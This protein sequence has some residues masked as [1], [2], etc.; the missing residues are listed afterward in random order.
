MHGSRSLA[1]RTSRIAAAA[2]LLAAG[3][4]ANGCA[5]RC[6][7]TLQTNNGPSRCIVDSCPKNSSFNDAV[8]ACAC[9]AGFVPF[10]GACQDVAS[11]NAACGIG[12]R[13]DRGH[14]VA[15][16]CHKGEV[17]NSTTGECEAKAKVYAT[18]A[19][20]ADIKLAAGQ[21]LA[22][23]AGYTMVVTEGEGSCVPNESLCPQGTKYDGST[24]VA[25]ATCAAGEVLD[26]TGKCT[27]L[28]TTSDTAKFSVDLKLHSS[29][30]SAFCSPLSKS[31]QT[32]GVSPGAS[33]TLKIHV[34]V[35][36]PD[37]EIEKTVSDGLQVTTAGGTALAATSPGYALV[38]KQVDDSVVGSIRAIGGVSLETAAAGDISCTISRAPL[39]VVESH[40][41]GI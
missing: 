4:L 31:P 12:N 37:N 16:T 2:A 25:L 18:V 24:C 11:A 30:T 36:T 33:V 15:K 40:G 35:A 14:C 5:G 13:Y 39:Q 32:F 1:A 38:K 34:S 9:T 26:A 29:L 8:H 28:A 3:A 27:K 23:A 41:G 19:A 22:C 21:E 6:W 7:V 20:K 10:N 17:L